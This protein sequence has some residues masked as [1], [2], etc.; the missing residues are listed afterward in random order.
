MPGAV[1]N[2]NGSLT[3]H[4]ATAHRPHGPRVK[5]IPCLASLRSVL[6]AGLYRFDARIWLA[7]WRAV[8]CDSRCAVHYAGLAGWLVDHRLNTTW[9]WASRGA[10]RG[11]TR[12]TAGGAVVAGLVLHCVG[13]TSHCPISTPRAFLANHEAR[14]GKGGLRVDP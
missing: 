11:S 12:G 2:H 8:Q 7:G 13:Q 10:T 1:N 14:D 5:E 6:A 9:R 4:S 3:R